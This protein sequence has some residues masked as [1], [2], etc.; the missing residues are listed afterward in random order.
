M[1]SVAAQDLTVL[2]NT[3][4][5]SIKR[6]SLKYR[7]PLNKPTK[8]EELILKGFEEKLLAGA[9]FNDLVFKQTTT[10]Y[11]EKTITTPKLYHN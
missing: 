11:K 2:H 5:T 9:N 1:C 8:Q 7:N 10:N 6:I 4:K 3:E